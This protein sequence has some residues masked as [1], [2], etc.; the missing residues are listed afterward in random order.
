MGANFVISSVSLV[1]V[2]N[3]DLVSVACSE[4]KANSKL[5]VDPDAPLAYAIPFKFL[6]SVT[7]RDFQEHDFG[8]CVDQQQLFSS[9]PCDIWWHYLVSLTLKQVAA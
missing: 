9:P 6:Q 4:N 2:D 8:S 3:F 5:V 1:I 7:R